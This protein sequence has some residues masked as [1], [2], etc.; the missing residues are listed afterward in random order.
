M[1][2]EQ[3]LQEIAEIRKRLQLV[4]TRSSFRC[5]SL[6][7]S[8]GLFVIAALAMNWFAVS[9][10]NGIRFV[11][12]WIGVSLLSGLMI[13]CELWIRCLSS[14]SRITV[15]WSRQVAATLMPAI[16]AAA[17]VTWA[18]LPHS[19]WIAMLPGLWSI[20]AGVGFACCV[21]LLPGLSQVAALWWIVGGAL[22]IRRVDLV[23]EHVSLSMILLFGVGQLLL[24]ASLYPGVR[25]EPHS[26]D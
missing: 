10:A 19:E 20:L 13:S 12:Y 26:D 8:S 2:P 15:S 7:L 4:D 21:R 25:R 11:G 22:A 9:P 24:T 17:I 3:A 18:I 6:A 14:R 16:A 5:V 23:S 1:R